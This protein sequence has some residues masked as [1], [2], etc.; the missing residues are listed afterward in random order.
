MYTRPIRHSSVVGT[1]YLIPF[2]MTKGGM[3]CPVAHHNHHSTAILLHWCTPNCHSTACPVALVHTTT[4][5]VKLF[6]MSLHDTVFSFS[7]NYFTWF[8]YQLQAWSSPTQKVLP[9]SSH[10]PCCPYTPFRC[11]QNLPTSIFSPFEETDDWQWAFKTLQFG[12]LSYNA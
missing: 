9:C 12:F 11:L 10:S 6:T 3:T 1:L 2:I 4:L 8:E 5:T 7:R